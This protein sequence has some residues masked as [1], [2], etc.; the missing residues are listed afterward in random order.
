MRKTETTLGD[1]MEENGDYIG[2]HAPRSHSDSIG[3]HD[4]EPRQRWGMR[5]REKET[6]LGNK[7]GGK[8]NQRRGKRLKKNSRQH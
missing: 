1:M 3:R 2:L 8:L 7:S 6:T 5:P 4:E